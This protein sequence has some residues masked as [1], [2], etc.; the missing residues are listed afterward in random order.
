MPSNS[1]GFFSVNLDEFYKAVD[2]GM[3]EACLYLIY[4]C[5]TGK[6]GDLTAWSVTALTKYTEISRR[7]GK[8]AQQR[9]LESGITE[10]IKTG[11]GGRHPHTRI[12]QSECSRHAWL[13]MTFITGAGKEVAPIEKLRRTGEPLALK[14]LI[15][16]YD[17]C[18]IAEE[19]GIQT[20]VYEACYESDN[21]G[22]HKFFSIFGFK[23]GSGRIHWEPIFHCL[24]EEEKIDLRS[25]GKADTAKF[26]D[27]LNI[28]Q[29]LG[30]IYEVPT[31]F[32]SE[33]GCPIVS[34]KDPF[35][36]EAYSE[37]CSE[38]LKEQLPEL[39]QKLIGTYDYWLLVPKD[40]PN[41]V[42][43]GVFVPLYR[44]HTELVRAG[45]AKNKE[46][47]EAYL[48]ILERGKNKATDESATEYIKASG[49]DIIAA[50]NPFASIDD[51]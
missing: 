5:G 47:Y 14:L 48:E 49:D 51:F 7:R 33:D 36:N 42:L 4:S 34:I 13:P 9:L 45:Y 10:I 37:L 11:K 27:R 24:S 32:D 6:K 15:A 30:L 8:L 22:S 2:L 18:N 39:Y 46:R 21:I 23:G 29:E 1:K 41:A 12:N 19:G 20:D 44:Q 26:W 40:Y 50:S 28:L 25:E 43:K 3:N 16:F 31:L 35:T 17:Y 38:E